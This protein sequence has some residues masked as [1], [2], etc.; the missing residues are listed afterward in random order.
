MRKYAHICQ[1]MWAIHIPKSENRAIHIL[2]FLK[3]VYHIPSGAENGGYS[4]RCLRL[5]GSNFHL[6]VGEQGATDVEFNAWRTDR[7]S[8]V[9]SRYLFHGCDNEIRL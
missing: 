6:L 2:F 5:H 9:E 4:T 1:K 3:G 8:I 7:S